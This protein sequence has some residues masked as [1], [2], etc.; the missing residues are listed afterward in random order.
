MGTFLSVVTKELIKCQDDKRLK[1]KDYLNR[2]PFPLDTQ[3]Q[4]NL[5]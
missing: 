5:F 2:A 1:A 4:V 3:G